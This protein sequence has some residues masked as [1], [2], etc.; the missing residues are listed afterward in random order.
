VKT[1]APVGADRPRATPPAL[2]P[3][4]AP[5]AA[6][7]P[8]P[9]AAPPASVRPAPPARP[10][11]GYE[12]GL[13][14]AV[15]GTP[16]VELGALDSLADVKL[17]SLDG[18]EDASPAPPPLA[19][20]IAAPASSPSRDAFAVPDDEETPLELDVPAAPARPK[21]QLAEPIVAAAPPPDEAAELAPPAPRPTTPRPAT[22]IPAPATA[23]R[24]LPTPIPRA[25]T[26]AAPVN[27]KE[28]LLDGVTADPRR[29]LLAGVLL[30]LVVGYLPATLYVSLVAEA[31]YAVIVKDVELA[32]S[33]TLTESQWQDL[34]EVRR[35]AVTR[36]EHA[37]TRIAV[38]TFVVWA[39]SGVMVLFLWYRQVIPRLAAAAR[40]PIP[41]SA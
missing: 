31:K 8:I 11:G 22:P 27:A 4:P 34:R 36:L 6:P 9:K 39:M 28:R 13:S 29:A 19:E 24:R 26:S 10:A 32:Q 35:D 17:S 14:A 37:R 2:P 33:G 12:S 18:E 3:L 5:R 20:P 15:G 16:N 1:G 38:T 41:P 25:G 7:P 40:R 23:P 21:G 30:A